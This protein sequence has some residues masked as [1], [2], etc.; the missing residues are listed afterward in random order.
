MSYN[1][2]QLPLLVLLLALMCTGP[3]LAGFDSLRARAHGP[4][5]PAP[6]SG[7]SYLRPPIPDSPDGPAMPSP[8]IR[9]PPRFT[10]ESAPVYKASTKKIPYSRYPN[11]SGAYA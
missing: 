7:P 3:G 11:Y 2:V 9:P 5:P 1:N 6:P 8:H 4:P 10:L